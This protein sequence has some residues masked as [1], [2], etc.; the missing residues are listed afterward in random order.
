[1]VPTDPGALGPWVW[2][3]DD[4]VPASGACIL[5]EIFSI[6]GK[7]LFRDCD[8]RDAKCRDVFWMR[9]AAEVPC[10]SPCWRKG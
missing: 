6:Q 3:E 2:M 4:G 1:M 8:Q 10:T 5:G 7:K 9:G